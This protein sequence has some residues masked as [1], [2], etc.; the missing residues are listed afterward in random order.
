MT[1]GSDLS[2]E[3]ETFESRLHKRGL[4]PSTCQSYRRHMQAMV[5]QSVADSVRSFVSDPKLVVAALL[6]KPLNGTRRVRHLVVRHFLNEFGD[7][8]GASIVERCHQGIEDGLP[9]RSAPRRHLVDRNLGGSTQ[10][11]RTRPPFDLLS[12]DRMIA[13]AA[14]Q[15]ASRTRLRDVA[16]VALHVRSTL[17]PHMIMTRRWGQCLNLNSAD[18]VARLRIEGPEGSVMAAVHEDP[19]AALN[20]L[21]RSAGEP[22]DGWVFRPLGVST[23]HLSPEHAAD[24]IAKYS[25]AI[26]LP[27]QDR[28]HLRAPFALWLLD[29]GWDQR[30]VARACGL[31][32]IR[33]LES[34]LGPLREV[35]EQL[36]ATEFLDV[37]RG[38]PIVEHDRAPITRPSTELIPSQG[39]LAEF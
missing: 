29:R 7:E 37:A 15:P 17:T 35:R 5:K 8:L 11:V 24:V 2:T 30:E 28:R 14:K 23:R 21:W 18:E 3:L 36:R 10:R 33:S 38:H 19:I 25:A 13:E 27:R 26:G 34:M 39:S 4:A 9:G 6:A 12:A 20:A 1:G 31:G 16:L 22:R 32:R